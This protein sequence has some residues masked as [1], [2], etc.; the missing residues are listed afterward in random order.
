MSISLILLLTYPTASKLGSN[1]SLKFIY[2]N[3]KPFNSP[4]LYSLLPPSTVLYI[5]FTFRYNC[6]CH[7][8]EYITLYTNPSY[9]QCNEC[10]KR[11]PHICLK[12][13]YCY[14]CHPKIER[15]EKEMEKVT[16]LHRPKEHQRVSFVT[17][18]VSK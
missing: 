2:T 15:I 8:H 10:M 5:L 9:G 3:L 17:Y 4:F 14:S 16:K 12:C 6:T 13:N 11:T 1:F 7:M 18:R